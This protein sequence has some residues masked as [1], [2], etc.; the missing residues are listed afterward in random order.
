LKVSPVDDLERLVAHLPP[1]M[2]LGGFGRAPHVLA[3][4]GCGPAGR[5]ADLIGSRHRREAQPIVRNCCQTI[6]LWSKFRFFDAIKAENAASRARNL[7][8]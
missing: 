7:K 5:T 1:E 4:G 6:G 3:D 8:R 2:L